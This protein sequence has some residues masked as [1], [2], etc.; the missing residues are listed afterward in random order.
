MNRLWMPFFINDYL[1]DTTALTTVEHGAY[2]LLIAN[3]SIFLIL[4]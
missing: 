2:F 3:K 4:I 1:A